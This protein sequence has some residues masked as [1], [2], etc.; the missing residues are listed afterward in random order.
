MRESTMFESVA[1]ELGW[2]PETQQKVLLEYI[3]SQKGAASFEAF[4]AEKDNFEDVAKAHHVARQPL[5]VGGKFETEVV[6]LRDSKTLRLFAVEADFIEDEQE[7]H[8]PY[9]AGPVTVV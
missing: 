9:E 2:S 1:A 5:A 4:L 8:S 3:E 7:V 6:V